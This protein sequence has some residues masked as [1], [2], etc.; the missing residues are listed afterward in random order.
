[1]DG[2]PLGVE[3]ILDHGQESV[4]LDVSMPVGGEMPISKQN[5]ASICGVAN[6]DL[7]NIRSVEVL[8]GTTDS[9]HQVGMVV[10]HQ[11]TNAKIADRTVSLMHGSDQIEQVHAVIHPM[12]SGRPFQPHTLTFHHPEEIN[13][14]AMIRTATA[15]C[16]RWKGT[17]ATNLKG[18]DIQTLTKGDVTRHLVPS[19]ITTAASPITTLFHRNMNN[20]AFMNG[21]YMPSKRKIVGDSFIVT[22]A[23]MT[24]AHDS[25]K[26]NLQEQ[27]PVNGLVIKSIAMHGTP[28]KGIMNVA[29]KINREPITEEMYTAGFSEGP[30]KTTVAQG[31][32]FMGEVVV[33]KSLVPMPESTLHT[34]V[35]DAKMND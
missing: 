16:A 26:A 22:D 4:L 27:S 23:H 28:A 24:S 30:K 17:D 15:R 33:D 2:S 32:G 29:L 34:N 12:M 13:T 14:A 21:E 19:D 20:A 3:N 5:L 25:L 10:K 11:D 31:L 9:P 6:S 35:F 18:S 1:M 7:C 8:Q